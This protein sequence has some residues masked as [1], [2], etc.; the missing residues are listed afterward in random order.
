[1]VVADNWGGL[2]EQFA[3]FLEVRD[4]H[5]SDAPAVA[6]NWGGLFD[7]GNY[8]S[9]CSSSASVTPAPSATT[10]VVQSTTEFA[11]AIQ[12]T[13]VAQQEAERSRVLFAHAEQERRT[14]GPFLKEST[15]ADAADPA[16]L[17]SSSLAPLQPQADEAGASESE[18]AAPPSVV[19]EPYRDAAA[20]VE[21]SSTGVDLGLQQVAKVLAP[22]EYHEM[23]PSATRLSVMAS[24]ATW[25]GAL[26]IFADPSAYI[27]AVKPSQ[28]SVSGVVGHA[29]TISYIPKSYH[30]VLDFA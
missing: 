3:D 12:K 30:S 17:D 25:L 11:Q 22:L 14:T 19:D 1:M 28:L 29:V 16:R 9:T 21:S 20:G 10:S 23:A 2:F 5:L 18:A 27:L 7:G 4:L 8:F 15:T 13:Q 26:T 6:H 24:D